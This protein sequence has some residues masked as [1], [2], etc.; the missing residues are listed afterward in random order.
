MTKFTADQCVRHPQHGEG[1]VVADLGATV[2]VRFGMA[3]EQVEAAE[4]SRVRSLMDALANGRFD[5]ALATLTRAQ[6]LAIR[7]VNDQWGVFS[8]SRVQLLPHQLWVCRQVTRTWPTRWLVADD[9]GLGKTIEAGLIVE[10][11]LSSGRVRRLL[12]LTPARLVGQWRARLKTMFDIRLQEYAADLDRGRINFWE[13][14]QQVVASFHTLRMKSAKERL[15]TAEPWDLIIVDEAHHFQAQER[16]TTLTFSLLQALEDAGKVRSLVLFTGTPHRGKDYGFMALMKLVRPD[17]FDPER[18][19][20]AQLPDLHKAMIRNNKA[21]VTD[22]Q[23]NKLFRPVA[24]ETVDYGYSTA[25]AAFYET[26]SNFIIDGRAYALSLTGRQQTARMLLLIALQKLAASSIAAIGAALERRRAMLARRLSDV[27]PPD[28]IEPETLDEAAEAEESRP[29]QIAL[30][31]M[32]D[33]IERLGEILELARK[34][35]QETKVA[36]LVDLI[37]TRLSA[38]EPVLLF[39]EYK[40]TQSLVFSSIE[41]RFGPGCVG[42]IN[43][44]EKLIVAGEAKQDRILQC[45]RDKAAADFNAGRTRFLISTEAGGEGIDLQERCATLVHVDLPWN[46]MRLHQRVGRLNRYGQKRA[47]QVFLLRNPETVEARIWAL[48]QEKLT[49][50]Q[51]ALS[52]SMEEA[53]DISQLVIGMT[54][55]GFFDELFAEGLRRPSDRLSDWFN[56]KTAQFGGT[57]AVEAVRALVGNVARYDFQSA[58]AEIPK[59]DLPALEPFFRQAMLL[60]NRRVTRS[61]TGLSVAT[62]ESW[63][64]SPDL[65]KRYDG[66][67]L[68]RALP[69]DQ[70]MVK[71]LGIG[72]PLMDRALA[73]SSEREALF[74]RVK[75]LAGPLLIALSED[76]ITGTGATVH[77][78]VLGL[79]G[80]PE[81]GV[82]CLRDWELL[83]NL[84]ELQTSSEAA[85][86]AS[87][88]EVASIRYLVDNLFTTASK[89]ALPFRRP[90]F[91]PMMAMLPWC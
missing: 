91:T 47:V 71:L 62:P 65:K 64:G 25:E 13:T 9:V 73:E 29:D 3:I 79:G 10:P 57:D 33:E 2:V 69:S 32:K 60:A 77:R 59:L 26:M 39:T 23:G 14:S 46:P 19:I 15:L 37:E 7:S 17:L 85:S 84:N 31:L 75:G 82:F 58:S 90:R 48:L 12:V 53:E 89:L 5:E 30:M 43:G 83:S 24:T 63:R 49:R 55:S 88:D 18:E 40:A 27:T 36:R 51:A 35:V 45:P 86:G 42:F 38:A 78:V 44:D 74:A 80:S 87:L 8:R 66:L 54:S 76:E 16:A 67:V 52:A 56:A 22:L 68:E 41:K 70:A 20:G 50:I 72:H 1:R 11:L 34:V 81:S 28:E 4:L 6:A 21:L 61:E